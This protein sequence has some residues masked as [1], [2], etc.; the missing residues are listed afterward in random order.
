M[1]C[2]PWRIIAKNSSSGPRRQLP[3]I[4]FSSVKLL[5]A[6]ARSATQSRTLF[7]PELCGGGRRMTGS[8]RFY[9]ST[10]EFPVKT[11]FIQLAH[12]TF[13]FILYFDN[14]LLKSKGR[15]L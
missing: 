15:E 5:P 11:G 6:L 1:A 4:F 10:A 9:R 7:I 13:S 12:N 8:G 3:R 2:A 14:E